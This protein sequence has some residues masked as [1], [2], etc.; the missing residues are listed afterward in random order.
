MTI[1]FKVGDYCVY[2]TH[3]V[4]KIVDIQTI[5]FDDFERKCLILYFENEKMTLSVPV[6]FKDNGDL[7]KLSTEED[8]NKVFEI[9]KS[10]QKKLKGMWS[11][12]AKEYEEKINSG[13]IF[14]LAE[15]L[16]DLI[17]DVADENRSFSERIIYESALERLSSEYALIKKISVEEAKNAI[18]EIAKNK[19][20]FTSGEEIK[21]A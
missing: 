19:I 14:D 2:K 15:V 5:K 20:S 1:N 6:K 8:M 7:R 4:A 12:R 10:G 11:R 13:N 21:E 16:Q 9:L 17:R 3:G 18:I